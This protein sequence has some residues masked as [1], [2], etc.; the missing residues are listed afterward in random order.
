MNTF[1]FF[2]IWFAFI[3]ICILFDA[4]L[5]LIGKNISKRDHKYRFV[6]RALIGFLM[7]TYFHEDWII[8]GLAWFLCGTTFWFIFDLGYNL[9]VGNKW[10]YI[11]E[12]SATDSFFKKMPN[13]V[14][15]ATKLSL[16]ILSFQLYFMAK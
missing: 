12:T 9:L 13:W 1:Q 3:V 8:K 14:M 15:L 2:L 5:K 4:S 11:G 6:F 10:N 7:S 16:L